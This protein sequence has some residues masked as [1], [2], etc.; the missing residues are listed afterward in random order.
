VPASAIQ[1]EVRG[2]GTVR[3]QGAACTFTFVRLRP[4]A[5]L[6]R[7]AG[8]DKGELGTAPIDEI[9]AEIARFG[10]IELFIDASE[11][12]GADRQASDLWT[13]W[14]RDNQAKLKRVS[15]VATSKL[16]HLVVSISKLVSNTGDL[17]RIY[18]DIAAFEQAMARE[19]A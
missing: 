13:A 11:A 15:I 8:N 6:V 10:Q 14:F 16:V 12:V 3:L 18:S 17:I 9:C 4:G 19:D 2:D 5:L 1:R 7:I